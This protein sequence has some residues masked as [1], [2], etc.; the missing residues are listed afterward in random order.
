MSEMQPTPW[1]LSADEV[2]AVVMRDAAE[3]KR[4]RFELGLAIADFPPGTWQEVF[5]AV[6]VLYFEEAPIHVTAI[7]D[8]CPAASLEWITARW[9]MGSAPL[10]GATLDGNVSI[11]KARARAFGQLTAMHAAIAD[12]KAAETDED[13]GA[14]IGRII[15][16]L[17]TERADTFADSTALAAGERF[18]AFMQ[19]E[20][21]PV[22]TTGIR[23]L[24]NN[25]GGIQRGQ[26]W[27]I[28]SPYKMRKSTLMRNMALAAARSGASVT[29]AAREGIQKLLSAQ[30]VAM[31]AVEYLLKEGHYHARDKHGI[32]LHAISA[33]LLQRLQIRYR[34]QLDPRQVAAVD[35]GIREFKR[36]GK[37]LRIYDSSHEFGGLSDLASVQ[38]V[39]RR[40]REMYGL[41]VLFLDYL[42]LLDGNRRD[43]YENVSHVSQQLQQMAQRD[44]VALVILA[45]LNEETVRGHNEGH[46]PGV[47]GGG[48]PAAAADFLFR[49]GYALDAEG[50]PMTD[51]LRVQIKLARHGAYGQAEVFQINEASGLI[52]PGDM[53]PAPLL[54]G[55]EKDEPIPF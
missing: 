29:I 31:L 10:G 2:L 4:V 48:D 8:R 27:Y 26:N 3:Y 52:L 11:L 39:M 46:S 30:L 33:S 51:Q 44:N 47:K 41:D 40:D 6:D 22:I 38:T 37:H 12:L 14:V 32:P 42:Q 45:Q 25:T 50:K 15:T 24:D 54:L 19:S 35:H 20:P 34:T 28:A 17:S 7:L 49:T 13:R 53:A 18:E 55:N 43:T 23:W 1:Q 16:Q 5:R 36:L 21:E 9:A